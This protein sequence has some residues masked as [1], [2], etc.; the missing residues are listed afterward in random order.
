MWYMAWPNRPF[1]ALAFGKSL[2]ATYCTAC[3]LMHWFYPLR[4]DQ[5][6]TEILSS[7]G[8][9]H[10]LTLTLTHSHTHTTTHTHTHT[11]THSLT[12]LG[13]W[14]NAPTLS[15]VRVDGGLRRR[16]RWLRRPWV[17]SRPEYYRINMSLN[18]AMSV[19]AWVLFLE[20]RDRKIL[21]WIP[22]RRDSLRLV[23]DT[24]LPLFLE[25]GCTLKDRQDDKI[26]VWIWLWVFNAAGTNVAASLTNQVLFVQV[27][28]RDADSP[29]PHRLLRCRS[30][31]SL[32]A[33]VY[34]LL[35]AL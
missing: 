26:P 24:L 33:L 1:D 28:S 12:T 27:S 11:H 10:T 8:C 3:N 2:T 9:H 13:L 6:S 14:V 20:C 15:S 21:E 29:L 32:A 31:C 18:Y 17:V 5:K 4:M 30:R 23:I 7:W 22:M 16:L 19:R 35:K 25:L 34:H